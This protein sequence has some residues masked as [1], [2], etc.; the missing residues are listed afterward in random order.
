MGPPEY[1]KQCNYLFDKMG[2][3][4]P[5]DASLVFALASFIPYIIIIIFIAL[6]FF[7]KS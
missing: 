4:G 1:C 6:T 7:G 5:P 3:C 2:A